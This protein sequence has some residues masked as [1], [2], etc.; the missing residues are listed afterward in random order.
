MRTFQWALIAT[1]VLVGGPAVSSAQTETEKPLLLVEMGTT[2]V[3]SGGTG[4]AI[5]D[6][7]GI[8]FDL[9]TTFPTGRGAWGMLLEAETHSMTDFLS[10]EGGGFQSNEPSR[11]GDAELA[12]LHYTFP[13]LGGE[14]SVGLLDSKVH[15]DGSEVAND[16]KEQFLGEAF[17]NNP[18]IAI[19]ENDLGL[20]Y[21]R[22]SLQY[23]PGFTLLAMKSEVTP[24]STSPPVRGAFL[25]AEAF[26]PFGPVLARFGAWT[27]RSTVPVRSGNH[28][29]GNDSGYYVSVDGHASMFSWNLRAG[30]AELAN[31]VEASYFGAALRIPLRQSEL[32][33]GAGR[34]VRNATALSDQ[35]GRSNYLELFFRF[36]AFQRIVITPDIQYEQVSG[37][38]GEENLL[39]ARVRF[40]VV[41]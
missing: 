14:W 23:I 18:A 3:A 28:W 35:K 30:K 37:I 33:I 25:A 11:S 15:I 10:R 4:D 2:L 27:R 12:E 1:A 26:K 19:P 32:G 16:D 24:V 17:V 40:R 39:T 29:E 38:H 7:G 22:E 34:S 13:A 36:T 6:K 8:G 9:Y 20:A 31:S 21:R 5:E 41:S